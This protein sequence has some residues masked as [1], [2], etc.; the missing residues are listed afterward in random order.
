MKVLVSGATGFVGAALCAKLEHEGH[1]VVR[2]VRDPAR[3]GQAAFLWEPRA[4]RLDPAAVTGLDAVVHLAGE[5][6]AQGRWTHE[7]KER[8]HQSRVLGTRLLAESLAR[9]KPPPR[10]VVSASAIGFYGDRGEEILT[11]DST[12][13]SGFLAEVCAAWESPVLTLSDA[14]IRPVVVRIGMV[15]GHGGG[16][17]TRLASLFRL[18]LGGV[19]GDG[20]QHVSWIHLD[21]LLRV[22]VAALG[23]PR[24]AGPIN[25]V[26]PE[27]VSNREFTRILAATVHRPAW[28]RIPGFAMRSI[29]GGM[30]SEVLLAGA[31]VRPARLESAG[32]DWRFP[33]L[34]AALN[35]LLKHPK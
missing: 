28:F 13:G 11:E 8:I 27:S 15:L 24:L 19:L 18:G 1:P 12:G 2:L 26:A 14:G 22:I 30:A 5:N 3:V 21:D 32:F 7:K 10:V 31:R 17:L 23:D 4:G 20:R 6:I 16:A 25:A 34:S 33:T 9:A 29:L 35:D